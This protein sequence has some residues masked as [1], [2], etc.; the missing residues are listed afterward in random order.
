MSGM[1]IL[2]LLLCLGPVWEK[3]DLRR[4][5][6]AGRSEY[7]FGVSCS[8]NGRLM[9]QAFIPGPET[10]MTSAFD[11]PSASIGPTNSVP[12]H[13]DQRRLSAALC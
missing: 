6:V 3:P 11:K 9:H 1:G 5:K 13:L 12:N 7:D 8:S 2:R 4:F 10:V